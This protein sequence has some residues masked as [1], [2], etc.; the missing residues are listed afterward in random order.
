MA[1]KGTSKF[2]VTVEILRKVESLAS[3]DL[4]MIQIGDVLG[5]SERTVYN[6]KKNNVQFMQSIKEGQA[7]GVATI[8]NALFTSAE[9]G[10]ITAQIFYLKNRAA[11]EWHDRKEIEHSGEILVGEIERSVVKAP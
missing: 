7:K 5:V 3:Q 6:Y 1:A 2:E 11:A 9:G 4:T 8:S 10:N